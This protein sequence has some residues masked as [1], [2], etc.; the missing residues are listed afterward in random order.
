M[1][2]YQ[3]SDMIGIVRFILMAYDRHATGSPPGPVAPMPWVKQAVSHAIAVGVKPSQ[4]LLGVANYGYDWPQGSTNAAT[5]SY[6][7]I[8]KMNVKPIWDAASGEYHFT[9]TKNGIT[10]QVWFEGTRSMSEKV[11]L[12]KAQKLSGIAVWRLGYDN[13]KW[14]SA[15]ANQVGNSVPKGGTVQG[16]PM[17]GR[18]GT[19]TASG[20]PARTGT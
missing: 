1:A 18:S 5:V 2:S 19:G 7:Q 10:H 8:S 6:A 3:R 15:L 14:W 13:T 20:R 16:R 17:A 11:S 4:L 12:A 9:Y